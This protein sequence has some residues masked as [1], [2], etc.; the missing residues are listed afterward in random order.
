M[1]SYHSANGGGQY[2]HKEAACVSCVSSVSDGMAAP[3]R[4]PAVGGGRARI[5]ILETE[6]R[7]CGTGDA[8]AVS[9]LGS[10]DQRHGR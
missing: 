8:N 3:S 6:R 5:V 2:W 1:T 9:L 4:G 7:R 10:E